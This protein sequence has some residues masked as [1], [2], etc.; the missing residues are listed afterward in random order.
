MSNLEE[1]M[2]GGSEAIKLELKPVE[3]RI[4]PNRRGKKCKHENWLE[5]PVFL[6]KEM[7][8]LCIDCGHVL[9]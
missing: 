5:T 2:T 9:R 1:F 3:K 8:R 7:K 4:L 6:K